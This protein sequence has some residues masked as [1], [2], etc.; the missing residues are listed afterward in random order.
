MP[1]PFITRVAGATRWNDSG[2]D[3]VKNGSDFVESANRLSCPT[4][5]PVGGI[6]TYADVANNGMFCR[7]IIDH[8]SLPLAKH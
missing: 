8:L 7:S 3:C 4:S 5:L 2:I 6:E 1:R